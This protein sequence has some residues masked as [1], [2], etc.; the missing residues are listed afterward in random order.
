[1]IYTTKPPYGTQLNWSAPLNNGL[2]AFW[3]LNEGT[4]NTAHDLSNNNNI[5][6]LNNISDPPTIT[7]GWNIGR[8]GVALNLDGVDDY[9][10]IGK[11][12]SLLIPGAMT[13]EAWVRFE[14][15]ESGQNYRIVSKQG[16][17][18]ARSWNINTEG[19]VCAFQIAR[20]ANTLIGAYGSAINIKEWTQ[21]VGVY[22][23]G[24]E[25]SIYKN[26]ILEQRNTTNIPLS[27]YINNGLDINIGRR[28]DGMGYI[29]GS[30]DQVRIWNRPPSSSEIDQLYRIPYDVFSTTYER[31]FTVKQGNG[32]IEVYK[33]GVLQGYATSITPYTLSNLNINDTYRWVSTPDNGYIFKQYCWEDTLE[34]EPAI[35][36][37]SII[38]DTASTSRTIGVYFEY[39]ASSIC[40]ITITQ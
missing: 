2:V 8:T 7:S 12:P 40:D 11:P 27:Q 25:V 37:S 1:M 21:L 32:K 14:R 33:N 39:C 10:N 29:P 28:P 9:I 19:N 17:P 13:V 16:G 18:G 26:G 34:C 31:T 22:I 3:I 4:G 23:P 5:G 24:I 35:D 6:T 38:Y 30:I 36:K 15:F 20:D